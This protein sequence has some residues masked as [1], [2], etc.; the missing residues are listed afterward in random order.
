MR[1]VFFGSSHGVPEP[2]R[3]CSSA[4]VS[5]GE[6]NYFIDMGVRIEDT[7]QGLYY[8]VPD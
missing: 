3:K 1:I 2:N 4:M 7:T 8:H 6:N 5:V